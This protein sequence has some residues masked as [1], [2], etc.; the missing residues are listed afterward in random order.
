[1]RVNFKSLIVVVSLWLVI[2]P[3]FAEH[4]EF[5]ASKVLMVV[6]TGFKYNTQTAKSNFYQKNTSSSKVVSY[7]AMLE[8][9][10]MVKILKE[11]GIDVLVFHQADTLPDA[12]FP[13]NWFTTDINEDGRTNIAVYPML[14]KNRQAEVNPNLLMPFLQKK[15]IK[16]GSLKDFRSN[17][18]GS[19]EGTGS[20]IFD[21][22]HKLIY[23]S[24]SERTSEPMVKKVANYRKYKSIVF[25]S[26]DKSD[27]LIYH[28]NVMMGLG[29]NFSVV[30]LECIKSPSERK[31]V[32]ATLTRTKKTIVAIT[33]DQV[34]H[35]CGNVLELKNR[36]NKYILV[37]SQQAYQHFTDNQRNKL[38][39]YAT[40]LPI[41]LTTIETVGG[42]SA[43]C[44]MAEIYAR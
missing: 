33:K 8:F 32:I 38:S 2:F 27:H 7:N 40:L 24:L 22:E 4:L 23:A 31:S 10:N 39:K 11:N 30:C 26:Y 37:M 16:I 36:D 13:N 29:H 17:A 6:P 43:R 44:M 14:A 19:L 12:V 34:S 18:M 41:D 1:M 3:V 42:G 28:T 21:K 9:D 5:T 15:G 20:M 25:S 35:M